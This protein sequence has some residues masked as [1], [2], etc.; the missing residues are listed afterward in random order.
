MA[1]FVRKFERAKWDSS[2]QAYINAGNNKNYILGDTFSKCLFT[3]QN[4]L[5]V[6]YSETSNWDEMKDLLAI[7]FSSCDGPGRSDV[8]IIN[9]TDLSGIDITS[10][11]GNA[12]V[13]KEYNNLHRNFSN[14]N[15]ELMGYVAEK[16]TKIIIEDRDKDVNTRR[17]RRFS[18]KNVED[19]VKDAANKGIIDIERACTRER[20]AARLRPTS[21]P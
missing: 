14:I 12:P 20:W 2:V 19:I 16:I 4:T 3:S 21:Y 9:E 13:T 15:Y 11:P 18:Q 10:E 1:F 8:I 6:W 17:F 7:I 5:S